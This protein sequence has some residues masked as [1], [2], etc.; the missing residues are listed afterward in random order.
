MVH[1][2]LVIWFWKDT[3]LS[4]IFSNVVSW[5]FEQQFHSS[6]LCKSQN[7]ELVGWVHFIKWIHDEQMKPG[8]Y[9][10]IVNCRVSIV[11]GVEGKIRSQ[12]FEDL[13]W[14]LSTDQS[15]QNLCLTAHTD[16]NNSPLETRLH[17]LK[18]YSV[19]SLK[20]CITWLSESDITTTTSIS[21]DE[22]RLTSSPD[23]ERTPVTWGLNIILQ[24]K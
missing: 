19:L 22:T 14:D 1:G 13:P 4:M 10:V 12:A 9:S 17:T 8:V 21:P 24:K 16:S 18:I 11:T 23:S 2:Y 3:L 15:Q 20:Q 7:S 5:S 6:I